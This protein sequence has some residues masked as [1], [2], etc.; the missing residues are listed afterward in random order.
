MTHFAAFIV[1]VSI[2]LVCLTAAFTAVALVS[3]FLPRGIVVILV[4]LPVLGFAYVVG[5]GV[6]EKFTGRSLF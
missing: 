3:M 4:S 6:L 5:V 2:V 1:G